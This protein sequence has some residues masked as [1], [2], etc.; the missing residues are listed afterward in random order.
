MYCRYCILQVYF[1]DEKRVVYSNFDDLKK[2]IDQKLSRW[3]GIVR[4]GT[5][6]F[7]DSLHAEEQTGLSAAIAE[8]L[9][10]Y[11]DV[12]VEFKTK[13]A[14]IEPLEKIRRPGKVIVAFSL[15]T[16]RMIELM[17]R[18]TAPLEERFSAARR[19][20]EMG[21]N[22]A[23]HFDPI[24][25]Y[26]GWE[27][28]YGGVVDMIYETVTDV[29]K[30]AWCSLGGFRSNPA[31]KNHLKR[32]HAHL[33]LFSGEMI[34]GDDGKLRYFRPLRVAMYRVMRNAFYRHQGDAP[35]YLCME[36]PEV[37]RECGMIERIPDGLPAYLDGRAAALLAAERVEE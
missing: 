24:F 33:P 13:S 31:L 8:L 11:P 35:V 26:D 28:E 30:I 22:V 2:E 9:E 16:P 12:I 1:E 7:T 10:P 20:C 32:R 37:W 36:S 21:F 19:C 18:N 14:V 27:R 5:G 3:K 29:K 34:T 15:N 6:E 4:F 23:F 25:W 17:E